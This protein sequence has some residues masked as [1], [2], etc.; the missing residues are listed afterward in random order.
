MKSIFIFSILTLSAFS[1]SAQT[2]DVPSKF[3]SSLNQMLYE[4]LEI[5]DA[6]LSGN[7]IKAGEE[8]KELNEVT[9]KANTDSLT[10]EQ[11]AAYKK[12]ADKIQHNAEHIQENSKNYAHQLE[13]FDYLTDEFYSLLKTF[14]F[15]DKSIYYN[16]TKE[17]NEGNSAHWLTDK[18][19][20]SNPYFKGAVKTGDI[21][22]EV[23][24]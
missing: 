6:L 5:E 8:A 18:D 21:R 19:E 14:R 13:H 22:I 12:Q 15:N 3:K 7:T 20:L 24:K 10:R 1:I 11:L 17:G 2:A 16:Y 9:A 4:Y 23:L